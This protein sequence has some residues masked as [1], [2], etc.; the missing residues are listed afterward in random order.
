MW[1]IVPRQ[2][3]TRTLFA[4][5]FFATSHLAR[6]DAGDYKTENWSYTPNHGFHS[7]KKHCG[8]NRSAGKEKKTVSF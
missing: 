4:V 2:N 7:K 6:S 3:R 5:P 1:A 8:I